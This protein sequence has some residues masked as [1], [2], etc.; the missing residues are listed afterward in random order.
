MFY[1]HSQ[2]PNCSSILFS[3]KAPCCGQSL[4]LHAQLNS[5]ASHCSPILNLSGK[6]VTAPPSWISV[7]LVLCGQLLLLHLGSLWPVTA[8]PS[9]PR[10]D[11]TTISVPDPDSMC[12][13]SIAYLI[14][15]QLGSFCVRKTEKPNEIT[16]K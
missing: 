4:L 9:M 2:G 15:N 6:S 7:A 8:P 3:I 14:N 12:I 13:H 10:Q 5:V 16:Q 1:S 11:R